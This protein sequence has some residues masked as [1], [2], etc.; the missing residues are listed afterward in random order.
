MRRGFV[1][2]FAVVAGDPELF[3]QAKL[4]Q[5]FRFAEN[6]FGENFFV[7]KI[8][9]PGP[10]PNQ[11]DQENRERDYR[12]EDDRKE[13]LQDALKHESTCSPLIPD[14]SNKTLKTHRQRQMRSMLFIKRRISASISRGRSGR[15][16]R[17][18]VN[19]TK[20]SP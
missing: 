11:I 9:A 6:N 14:W 18:L 4:R 15:S 10:K 2:Q 17:I 16:L 12:E 8:Q 19:A 5:Q 20:S 13:P 7:K 3:D 1:T